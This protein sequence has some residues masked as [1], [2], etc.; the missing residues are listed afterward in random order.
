MEALAR[1]LHPET[2]EKDPAQLSSHRPRS[3][4]DTTGKLCEKILFTRILYEAG[5]RGLLGDD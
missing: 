1:D 3:L 2:R 4:L 5:G